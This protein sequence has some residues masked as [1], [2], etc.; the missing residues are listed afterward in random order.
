MNCIQNI[1]SERYNASNYPLEPIDDKN[2]HIHKYF[3]DDK[4]FLNMFLKAETLRNELLDAQ[5][6]LE[7][8]K[9]KTKILIAE[10]SLMTSLIFIR[11]MAEISPIDH[12]EKYRLKVQYIDEDIAMFDKL[13]S[14]Y[15]VHGVISGTIS[16]NRNIEKP[17]EVSIDF[18]K[19][20]LDNREKLK[21][22]HP[23]CNVLMELKEK[24]A[25]RV[26]KYASGN[27]FRP[28]EPSYGSFVKVCILFFFIIKCVNKY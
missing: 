9:T 4:Q 10:L 16:E 5:K 17:S 6:Q 13:L 21:K 3:Q 27:T 2:Q 11:I 24:T 7:K 26:H 19:Q 8:S 23:Y 18:Y 20:G 28:K 15:Y 22:V 12:V 14:V 1:L 25:Q